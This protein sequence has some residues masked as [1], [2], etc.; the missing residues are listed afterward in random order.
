MIA[1]S[2]Q[3]K[4]PGADSP[5]LCLI[6]LVLLVFTT[7]ETVADQNSDTSAKTLRV[8]VTDFPPYIMFNN[9]QAEGIA[10]DLL[11]AAAELRGIKL[12]ASEVP[13]ARLETFISEKRIDAA[14]RPLHWTPEPERFSFSDTFLHSWQ[15]L[16]FTADTQTLYETMEDLTGQTIAA[17]LGMPCPPL[18][19]MF[20]EG[21]IHRFD[22]QS[23]RALFDHLLASS[24]ID[25]AVTDLYSG[26]WVI[27]QNDWNEQISVAEQ[28]L[29]EVGHRIMFH[30]DHDEFVE[31]FNATLASMRSNGKLSDIKDRYLSDLTPP[32]NL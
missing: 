21:A 23:L 27:H 32:D 6:L 3:K 11:E 17:Q 2:H 30:S 1:D 10:W 7:T 9:A 20:E 15:I 28:P 31:H 13:R 19:P 24:E 25:A 5:I 26:L 29:E 12:V 14:L 16:F 4:R 8:G 22:V 18:E